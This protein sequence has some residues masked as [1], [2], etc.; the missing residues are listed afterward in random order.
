MKLNQLSILFCLFLLIFCSANATD[1]PSNYQI[2]SPNYWLQYGEQ[3]LMYPAD[4]RT[5]ISV[6]RDYRT[7]HEVAIGRSTDGGETWSESFVSPSQ[8]IFDRLSDPSIVSDNGGNLYITMKDYQADNPSD[9]SHI[10]ILKSSD[11][12]ETWSESYTVRDTIGHYFECDQATV[13]DNTGG[14]NAGNIYIS[15]VRSSEDDGPGF[16]GPASIMFSK[17]TDGGLSFEEP[18]VVGPPL[19]VSGCS[20]I[21]GNYLSAGEFSA[22]MVGSDGSIYVFWKYFFTT[23]TSSGCVLSQYCFKMVK[24]SDAGE[25]WS[26]VQHIKENE[27]MYYTID[28]D[29]T[30]NGAPILATDNSGGPSD[31]NLYLAYTGLYDFDIYDSDYNIEFIKSIDGG[32][33]WSAPIYINDD[34]IGP[35]AAF[36]QFHPNMVCS[37][38]GVIIIVFYDQKTDLVNHS[39]FDV[40]ASYSFDGGNTFTQNHRI[41]E[42][43]IDPDLMIDTGYPYLRVGNTIGLSARG[44]QICAAWTDTR[45]GNQDVFGAGWDIPLLAPTLIAPADNDLVCETAILEWSPTWKHDDDQYLIEVA[46]DSQ[47]ENIVVS[48]TVSEPILELSTTGLTSGN[49]YWRVRAAK[50]STGELTEYSETYVFYYNNDYPPV[51]LPYQPSDGA[52]LSSLP[53]LEWIQIGDSPCP[54]FYDLEISK[55]YTFSSDPD[56][57]RYTDLTETSLTL[58]EPLEM[59]VSYYWHVLSKNINGVNN[60]YGP[61][62]S[63]TIVP[64]VCGDVFHDDKGAINILD[65]VYIIN[66]KYKDGPAIEPIECGDVNSDYIINIL[67]VVYLIN[68]VYKDGPAPECPSGK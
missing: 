34:Y 63:F 42:I 21:S 28:G 53:T 57:L 17:S 39:K 6:W 16:Y 52:S 13:I 51:P 23:E 62:A 50:I 26:S 68:F 47:F 55:N 41:S 20:N 43:S 8:H 64:F 36:D 44:E 27:L 54:I 18:V 59:N 11:G 48:E 61:T 9:S 10:T 58:T 56:I 7:D 33:T 37:E 25:T 4:A 49:K 22:I 35:D 19:D 14:P 3:I 65:I 38:D 30:I 45:N 24:S 5:I 60:Y 15:W 32:M 2:S 66:N 29:I 40:M 12:G 46:D 31:G 1:I 67:D